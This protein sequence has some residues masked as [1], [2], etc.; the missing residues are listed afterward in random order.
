QVKIG[1]STYRKAV[2]HI[3][4]YTLPKKESKS[5]K[6]LYKQAGEIKDELREVQHLTLK[7]NLRWMDVELALATQE[8]PADN[9]IIDGFE[10]VE[11]K[12]EGLDRKSTRLNSS[13]VSISYAVFCFYNHH[14]SLHT[15]PTRRSSDLIS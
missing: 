10:T 1:E 12:V 4:K 9:T 15:F 13:H 8:E 14:Q 6:N 2:R 11:K 7:N 5:L 3:E